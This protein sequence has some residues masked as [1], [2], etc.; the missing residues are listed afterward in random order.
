MT[1]SLNW[2][3][4]RRIS[5]G[6]GGYTVAVD[7]ALPAEQANVIWRPEQLPDAVLLSNAPNGFQ[8]TKALRRSILSKAVASTKAADGVHALLPWGQQVWQL[9]KDTEAPSAIVI[10]LDDDFLLRIAAA[11]RFNRMIAGECGQ[12]SAEDT[13]LTA[14]HRRR[15]IQMLRALDGRLSDA[16]YREIASYIFGPDPARETGWKTHPVRAQTI[17]LVKDAIKI[18]NRGYL[19]LLRGR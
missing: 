12:A 5:P 4:P 17:R 7:P 10:P 13:R 19:K 1:T 15:L 8:Q 9:N 11:I 3:T 14:Q 6:T 18:V 2:P 16:T